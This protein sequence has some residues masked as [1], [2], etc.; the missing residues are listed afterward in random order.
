MRTRRFAI[1]ALCA[2]TAAAADKLDPTLTVVLGGGAAAGFSG[3]RLLEN[4]QNQAWPA[5]AAKQMGTYI[6]V[7]TMRESPMTGV[8][9]AYRPLAG[10]L[11]E[12]PQSGERALPFPFFAMNLSVP[13][14]RT[15]DALRMRPTPRNDGLNLL[16]TVEGDIK[17]TLFNAIVGGPL[18]TFQPPVL[19]TAADYVVALNPTL[20]F[21]QLGF[22]DVS[23]AAAGGDASR[24]TDPGSFGGDYLLLLNKLRTTDATIV[25]MTVPDPTLTGYFSTLDDAA[26]RY[27]GS[28]EELRARFGLA[29]GDLLTLG[30]MVEVADSMRGRRGNTL[31]RGSVLPA[32]IAASVRSA[33][34]S[35]NESIRSLSAARKLE[36]FDLADFVRQVRTAGVRAGAVTVTGE[37]GGGFYSEDGIY[38]S[39]A[40]Q[41]LTANAVLQFLNSKFGT[42]FPLATVAQ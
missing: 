5:V 6:S 18:L 40:G 2:W 15:G 21:V 38:P 28:A 29:A 22:E 3:F 31:S 33:V 32:S 42:G 14:M 1:A 36:V 10:L 8:V 24:I 35:Y 41:A 17:A 20:L 27:G 13:F 12:I 4:E 11:P 7:P 30:G 25:L 34:N 39:A 26:R 9:N 37:Y 16:T 19:L 23:E